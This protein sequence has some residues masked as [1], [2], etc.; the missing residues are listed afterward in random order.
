MMLPESRCSP[1]AFLLHY[2][3]PDLSPVPK[4][5]VASDWLSRVLFSCLSHHLPTQ[6]DSAGASDKHQT[7]STRRLVQSARI[8]TQLPRELPTSDSKVPLPLPLKRAEILGRGRRTSLRSAR[9]YACCLT[10]TSKPL[11]SISHQRALAPSSTLYPS[12]TPPQLRS[13]KS[14]NPHCHI[15]ALF[16]HLLPESVPQI[17][18]IPSASSGSSPL[19]SRAADPS[20]QT[21]SGSATNC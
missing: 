5:S 2:L 13:G 19:R 11:T 14:H 10:A 15:P 6:N 20:K 9:P 7:S 12:H 3:H 4:P 17:L 8:K 16:V 1:S 18:R 21:N